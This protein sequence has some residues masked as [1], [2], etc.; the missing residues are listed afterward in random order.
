M[1]IKSYSKSAPNK[2]LL[3][4]AFKGAYFVGILHFIGSVSSVDYSSKNISSIE[5]SYK[6]HFNSGKLLGPCQL[7][8]WY[9]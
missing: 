6:K 2:I 1:I 8:N 4:V 5:S 7:S 9:T 3:Q